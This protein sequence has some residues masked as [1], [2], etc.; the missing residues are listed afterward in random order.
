MQKYLIV[1]EEEMWDKMHSEDYTVWTHTYCRNLKEKERRA[2]SKAD[3]KL[4]RAW[5][6]D[7]RDKKAEPYQMLGPSMANIPGAVRAIIAAVREKVHEAGIDPPKPR[8]RAKPQKEPMKQLP[9]PVAAKPK[10]KK[11]KVYRAPYELIGV[12]TDD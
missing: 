11:V 8:I 10:E 7:W 2:R 5:I 1:L 9:P 4:L 6:V 3:G 12:G